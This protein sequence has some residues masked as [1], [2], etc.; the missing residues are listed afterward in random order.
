VAYFMVLT[1]HIVNKLGKAL[2]YIQGNRPRNRNS[3]PGPH[4]TEKHYLANIKTGGGGGINSKSGTSMAPQ[5]LGLIFMN[6][7]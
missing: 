1:V 6:L 2:K 3:S 4:D 5:S 7:P